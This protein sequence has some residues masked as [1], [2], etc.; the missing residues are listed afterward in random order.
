MLHQRCKMKLFL[1]AVSVHLFSFSVNAYE[2]NDNFF[3]TLDPKNPEIEKILLSLDKEYEM[4]TGKSSHLEVQPEMMRRCFRNSCKIW[5]S[6]DLYA[7]RFYL[8]IDGSLRFSWK[9]STGRWGYETPQ[10]DSHPN[11]RIYDRFVS[12]KYPEGDYNGLGNM[13][14]AVFIEGAYAIHGTT[15]G[16]WGRLGTPASHG[17]IRLHPDNAQ[18]FNLLVRRNGIW[19]VWVTIN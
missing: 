1:L 9:T 2:F 15:K 3:E 6:I 4:T 10:M 19:K 8:Y 5:A 12:K 13:P 17:C 14:Y 18:I 16:S 7:Q 11:G